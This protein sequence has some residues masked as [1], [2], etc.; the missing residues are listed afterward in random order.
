MTTA[1]LEKRINI[2]EREISALRAAVLPHISKIPAKKLPRGLQVALQ[3]VKAGRVSGP[4]RSV[5]TLM[6]HLG[7]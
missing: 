4:F 6:K 5:N 2:L 7:K 3:D 1:M